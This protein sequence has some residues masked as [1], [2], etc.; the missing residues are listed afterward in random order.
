MD[1]RNLKAFKLRLQDGIS[2]LQMEQYQTSIMK[3]ITE[4][5]EKDFQPLRP[6][7]QKAMLASS[8]A[9]IARIDAKEPP[10]IVGTIGKLDGKIMYH[11]KE[12]GGLR[13]IKVDDKTHDNWIDGKLPRYKSQMQQ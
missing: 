6:K 13:V 1:E 11:L 3:K 2:K 12:T 9:Q 8:Y 7:V 4:T 10:P 5:L